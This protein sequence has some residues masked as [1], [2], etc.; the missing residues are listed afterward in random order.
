MNDYIVTQQDIELLMQAN[1]TLYYKL[2]LLNENMQIV[3]LLEG[4]LISD[5]IS[6]SSDS[7]VRRTY[8]CQLIVTDSSFDIGYDKKI[9]LNKRIRPYIGVEHQ[10][11]GKVIFYLIGTFVFSESGFNY[12]ATTH[13]LSLTCN[14]LMCLLNGSL[15]GNLD[16]YSR[17]VT[18]GTS[19]REVI[20]S[21]LEKVGITKYFIEFNINQKMLSTFEIPYDMVYSAGVNAY[22]I[23]KEI[24]DLHPCNRAYFDINGTFIIDRIPSGKNEHIVLNDDIL[25][26]ILISEQMNTSF[27][28]VYNHIEIWGKLNEPDF[29]SK[30]LISSNGVYYANVI[31]SKLDE[32]TGATADVPYD[33]LDNF[34]TFSFKIPRTN[35]YPQ[36]ININNLGNVLIVREDGD[37]LP[38]GYLVSDTDYV[39][40][41]RKADN[42]F[43]FIGQYQCYANCYVTSN[44]NDTSE[45]AMIDKDNEFAIEKIGDK[46]K[47]ISGGDIDNIHTDSAC[48]QRCRYELYNAT[49]RKDNLSLTILAVPFLDVDQVFE[50]TTNS[51][52]K[53]N[54]YIINNISCNYSEFTMNISANRY[55]PEYI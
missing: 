42:T 47:V 6:I 31:T 26:P 37:P 15:G 39:F 7:D 16:A 51:N 9:W 25:Q 3:D 46:L 8:N 22:Q 14:D 49:N 10:R 35:S 54:K 28:E 34:D 20:I 4:N 27:S 52:R 21:L 24:V 38:A 32:T 55:Y 36:Y 48:R 40:R 29:Y 44:V 18:E 2:E 1:K 23:I 12:D 41:Y 5:S 19:A 17:T 50:Y 11:S 53:T 43:L 13:T 45:N 30:D 33:S